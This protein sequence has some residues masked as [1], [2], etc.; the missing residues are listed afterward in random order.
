MITLN[1]RPAPLSDI[2]KAWAARALGC[3]IAVIETVLAVESGGFGFLPDGRPKI[4]FEAHIFSR[5]TGHRFDEAHPDISS[6]RWN[7]DLY[8][9]AGDYQWRRLEAAVE[10]N[11]EAAFRSASW[12]LFQI[13]GDNHRLCGFPIVGP[14]VEA[15]R[16]AERNHLECFVTFIR[17]VKL[18]DELRDRR[19]IDFARAYNG[20]GYAANAYDAKLA[21]AF[22]RAIARAQRTG[23]HPAN[24]ERDMWRGVQAALNTL[25]YGPL[26]VDGWPGP[27]THAALADFQ[28][29]RKLPIGMLDAETRAALGVAA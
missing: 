18:D 1:G 4:L 23:D 5:L 13:L 29:D 20:P 17:A 25:G 22:A 16:R 6:P 28:A 11:A 3:E 15:H 27:R 8:G 24:D 19:W 14:F 7:R 2:D 9:R 10:L 12:G 21:A 26:V